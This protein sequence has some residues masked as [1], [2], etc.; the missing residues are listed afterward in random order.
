MPAFST[1]AS[2]SLHTFG[3]FLKEGSIAKGY[4]AAKATGKN[5]LAGAA[6]GFGAENAMT[7]LTDSARGAFSGEGFFKRAKAGLG[8]L[9]PDSFKA[10]YLKRVGAGLGLGA[11]AGAGQSYYN[12]D[13]VG[14]YAGNMLG[15]ALAG[16]IGGHMY[17]G[18]RTSGTTLNAMLSGRGK[19]G[20][21]FAQA[22]R[23]RKG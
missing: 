9:G 13:G 21:S 15:G 23:A 5:A 10:G 7:M 19:G 17:A 20:N 12:G 11:A 14:G 1:M 16:G 8:A 2:N 4:M 6:K 3:N 22:W 18:A